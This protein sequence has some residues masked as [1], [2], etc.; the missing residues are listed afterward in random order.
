MPSLVRIQPC[1]KPL[2]KHKHRLLGRLLPS[3]GNFRLMHQNAPKVSKMPV[4]LALFWHQLF[5]ANSPLAPN[6]SAVPLYPSQP[7]G[8]F[9]GHPRRNKWPRRRDGYCTFFFLDAFVGNVRIRVSKPRYAGEV[10]IT[11]S[12]ACSTE[13][14]PAASRR[15]MWRPV[16]PC[17]PVILI[18][19]I[20]TSGNQGRAGRT[21]H[22]VCGGR[23]TA[24]EGSAPHGWSMRKTHLPFGRRR[25]T[26]I[27][28]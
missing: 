21:R 28:W 12:M 4:I 3:D 19:S 9:L 16:K 25:M 7:T 13:N 1:P 14:P 10:A 22:S 8:P 20:T 24:H 26:S 23:S 18:A 17:S 27:A 5:L 15:V 2:N 11:V 6:R